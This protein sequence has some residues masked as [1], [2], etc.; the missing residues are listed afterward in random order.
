MTASKLDGVNWALWATGD[1]GLARAK[2]AYACG[3][4]PHCTYSREF[5][6][7]LSRTSSS[8]FQSPANTRFFS[9]SGSTGFNEAKITNNGNDPTF[10]IIKLIIIFYN[11]LY[12][13][14]HPSQNFSF[15]FLNKKYRK[16]YYRLYNYRNT[17]VHI[18][19]TVQRFFYNY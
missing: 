7:D 18:S 6:A 17:Y 3:I 5:L 14:L 15:I 19:I 16:I 13:D 12:N 11:Q 10:L 8:N 2:L 4:L 1:G 9:K